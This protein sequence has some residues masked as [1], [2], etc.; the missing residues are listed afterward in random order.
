MKSGE[1]VGLDELFV[2][3]HLARDEL[4]GAFLELAEAQFFEDVFDCFSEHAMR[5]RMNGRHRAGLADD[6]D[7]CL[8]RFS[9]LVGDLLVFFV[10]REW[11]GLCGNQLTNQ[12]TKPPK[13]TTEKS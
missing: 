10:M 3:E 4:E 8:S 5:M 1:A 11:V 12:Q 6:R 2:A 7:E 9:F 13:E